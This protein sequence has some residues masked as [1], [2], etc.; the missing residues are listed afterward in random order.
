LLRTFE[1]RWP[2]IRPTSPVRWERSHGCC[3][4][5]DS[6]K[7]GLPSVSAV[8]LASL[9]SICAFVRDLAD[10]R[11]HSNSYSWSDLWF[12]FPLVLPA[13]HIPRRSML[14]RRSPLQ[15]TGLVAI[16]PAA[17]FVGAPAAVLI[18]VLASALS[19]AATR[20]K[21]TMRVDGELPSSS[22]TFLFIS[23]QNE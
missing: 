15:R 23:L 1:R 14:I 11:I 9:L 22:P 8:R 5:I 12:V 3:S 18:G 17:G 21:N 10:H 7:S 2:S 6:R 4:I 13:F 20:L 19:N 16:T